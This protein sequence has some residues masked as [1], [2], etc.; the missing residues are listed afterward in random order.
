MANLAK[1]IRAAM[2]GTGIQFRREPYRDN[3]VRQFLR[4][5]IAMANAA[6]EGPRYIIIGTDLDKKGVKRLKSVTRDDFSD[7]PSYQTLVSEFVE[8]AIKLTYQAVTVDGKRLGVFEIGDCQE[9]PYMMRVDHCE[10]LRRGDA[11]IRVDDMPVKMGRRQLKE[12][13]ARK[14]H[15]SVSANRIEIGFPGEIIHK[16]IKIPTTDLAEMPSASARDK[17][18]QLLDLQANFKDG[19]ANSGVIRLAHTRLFGSDKPYEAWTPTRLMD[20]MAKIKTK[21]QTDDQHFLFETNPQNL[22][23]VV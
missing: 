2:P 21:Y 7:N 22:Q 10:K 14:F 4:D 6:A 1:I 19:G 5:V 9:H 13:F 15:D 11:Y 20:E 8:P 12:M 3:G 16:N 18:K 23:L 17:L